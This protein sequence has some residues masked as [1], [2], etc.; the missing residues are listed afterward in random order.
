MKD[1]KTA[2][3]FALTDTGTVNAIG[4]TRKRT[5]TTRPISS[6]RIDRDA[7]V[8]RGIA[9]S[10]LKHYCVSWNI[11]FTRQMEALMKMGVIN[12]PVPKASQDR[13]HFAFGS[14]RHA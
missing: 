8:F 6:M 11:S 10:R 13:R 5:P 4:G 7:D 14:S 12:A 1:P 2:P 3:H 9:T